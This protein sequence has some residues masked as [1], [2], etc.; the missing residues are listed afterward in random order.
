MRS[1]SFMDAICFSHVSSMDLM[2]GTFPLIDASGTSFCGKVT[3]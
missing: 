2:S 3:M 1:A